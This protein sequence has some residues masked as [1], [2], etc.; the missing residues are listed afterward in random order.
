MPALM[1]RQKGNEGKRRGV[2]KHRYRVLNCFEIRSIQ[3]TVMKQSNSEE[4]ELS[5]R[6]SR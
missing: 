5:C 6:G 4:N 3:K 1:S 2:A